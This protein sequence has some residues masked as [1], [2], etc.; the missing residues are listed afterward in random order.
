MKSGKKGLRST[1][2]CIIALLFVIAY[3]E[4]G[5]AQN[6]IGVPPLVVEHP[7]PAFG[8]EFG[9]G[10]NSQSGTMECD[11]GTTFTGGNGTGWFASAFFELP[12]G[13]DFNIGLKA[14]YDRENVSTS[15]PTNDI[16]TVHIPNNYQPDTTILAVNRNT[17]LNLA[18][19]HFEPFIQYQILHTDFFIQ[20]GAGISILSSNQFSET[21]TLG[22]NSITLSNGTTINNL[23]FM[24]GSNTETIQG[25]SIGG[26]MSP[27]FSGLFS[28][29]YN[30]RF[31][32][33]SIA[34]MVNYD[35]PFS[36]NSSSNGNN[37]KISTISG[38]IAMKFNLY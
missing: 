37:W 3:N 33:V 38:S 16:V 26:I 2:Q 25:G 24:N 29:G 6:S 30:F 11:C 32:I 19:F 34:P 21:R 31:G 17:T 7:S 18:F 8:F 13:N 14:G 27:Q 35:Y 22:S 12:I 23:T 36:T 20:L 5:F 9:E 4:A 10:H 28:A 1:V 15:T